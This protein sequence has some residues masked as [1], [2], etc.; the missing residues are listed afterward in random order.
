MVLLGKH[1]QQTTAFLFLG[2]VIIPS[3]IS[4]VRGRRN[5]RLFCVDIAASG[6]H[7]FPG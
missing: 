4:S 2:I 5:M 6:G 3:V 1:H 7:G